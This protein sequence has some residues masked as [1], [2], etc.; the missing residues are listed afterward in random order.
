[1]KREDIRTIYSA[2]VAELLNQGYT[3][4]PDSMRGSQGEIA[5]IDFIRGSEIIRVLLEHRF[6]LYSEDLGFHWHNG[7]IILTVGRVPEEQK[8]YI[9]GLWDDTIWNQRLEVIESHTWFEIEKRDRAWYIEE[10]EAR[11]VSE[12]R[13]ARWT[14]NYTAEHTECGDA[15]KAIAIRWL[16]K[17]PIRGMKSKKAS[18]IE[19]MRKRQKPNG[20]TYYQIRMRASGN[21]YDIG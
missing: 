21:F 15:H 4:Y 13:K 1:M 7:A 16:K 6:C 5:K 20:H 3:I 17:Q 14:R 11:R 12:I 10:E 2:K 9:R 19:F 18:D 8:C